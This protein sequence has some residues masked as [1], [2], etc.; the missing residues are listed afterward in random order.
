MRSIGERFSA[1]EAA[2]ETDGFAI[3]PTPDTE[4]P[5]LT[6][7]FQTRGNGMG[8]AA[9]H[10]SARSTVTSAPKKAFY[11]E[12]DNF[13]MGWLLGC[14]A[15]PDVA[16][17]CTDF[18]RDV[19]FAFFGAEKGNGRGPDPVSRAETRASREGLRDLIVRIIAGAAGKMLPDIPTEYVEEIDGLVAGCKAANPHTPV[20]RERLLALNLGIDCLLAH[21]YTGTLF[22][23]RGV[24]PRMLRT[25]I[26]CNAFSL[27]GTGGRR[28]FGRDFMFPTADV[29]QDTACL[30]IHVPVERSGRRRYA[31]ASQTAPGFVGSITAMNSA[32]VAMGVDMLPSTFCDPG[33]PGLN[34]L[35]L[36]RDCAQRCGSVAAAVSRIREAPRGV[37]WLYPVADAGGAAC[38]VEAGRATPRGQPFPPFGTIPRYYRRRLP[39]RAELARVRRAFDLPRP[40]RGTIA[41]DQSYRYP[42]ERIA[43]WNQTLWKAFDRDWRAKLRDLF[44]EVLGALVDLV[45]GRHSG[46]W[47]RFETDIGDIMR[48]VDY[49]T[50]DFSERGF[51]TPSWTARAC[52]GPF[53]FPPQRESRSDLLIVTNHA[54]CPE[55]RLTE[56]N[57]WTA[58]LAGGSQNDIQW[59]YDELNR[60]ILDALDSGHGTAIGGVDDDDAWRL[61]DFLNPGGD[62]KD[63]YNTGNVMDWRRVQVHGSVTLCELTERGMTSRFGYYGDDPVTIHLGRY[64]P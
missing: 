43:A 49:R 17:M 21:I 45:T 2:F 52:P 37:S 41:R 4:R 61:I 63:Y 23:E 58:L 12:G 15:E 13:E 26:G 38:V 31:F 20:S 3:H 24:H 44:G 62:I 16:R 14:M 29:F 64:L 46:M 28:F 42:A 7:P 6:R 9:T 8:I 10:R 22:A 47:K 1:I 59:R 27:S 48:G 18:A 55:M 32:G 25:P 35:L 34:S 36:V 56:M 54:L 33:R 57:E 40:D 19:V 30:V 60:R 51:I 11:V 50:A 39:G 5:G 53:Y